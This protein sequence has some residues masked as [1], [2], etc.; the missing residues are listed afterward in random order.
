MYTIKKGNLYVKASD[1]SGESSYTSDP[2][3]AVK[4]ESFE[5]AKKNACL[6]NET[7]V[8]MKLRWV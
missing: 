1:E 6:E 3:K 2:D 8:Q 7:V 4:Y 5:E